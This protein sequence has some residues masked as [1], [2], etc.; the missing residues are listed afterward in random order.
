MRTR[1]V[2]GVR[3]SAAV[4]RRASSGLV[5][6]GLGPFLPFAVVHHFDRCWGLSRHADPPYAESMDTPS[7]LVQGNRRALILAGSRRFGRERRMFQWPDGPSGL[8]TTRSDGPGCFRTGPIVKWHRHAHTFLAFEDSVGGIGFVYA[9]MLQDDADPVRLLGS[10][11]K[12]TKKKTM[13][14]VMHAVLDG[15]DRANLRQNR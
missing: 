3:Q 4:M 12:W 2:D 7:C 1:P 8:R 10:N 5:T 15:Q 11:E 6:S 9:S 13:Q 14:A